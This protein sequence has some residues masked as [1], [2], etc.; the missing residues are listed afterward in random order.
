MVWESKNL[1]K[2][3][4][5]KKTI[6]NRLPPDSSHRIVFFW[7]FWFSSTFWTS[8]AWDAKK[9]GEKPKKQ[10]KQSGIDLL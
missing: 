2:N 9:P 5:N 8:G 6:W 3:Q 4:K 7:F 1:E 10:K